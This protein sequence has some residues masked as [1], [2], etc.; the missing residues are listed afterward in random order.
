MTAAKAILKCLLGLPKALLDV[1]SDSSQQSLLA[2]GSPLW[3]LD[4]SAAAQTG[5]LAWL[6]SI[7]LPSRYG[8]HARDVLHCLP[9]GALAGHHCSLLHAVSHLC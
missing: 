8:F 3:V 9:K 4:L 6:D 5:L 7:K 2:D 1:A